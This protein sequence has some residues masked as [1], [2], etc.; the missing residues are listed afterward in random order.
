MDAVKILVLGAGAREHAIITALLREGVHEVVSAGGN[1]GNS[2]EPHVHAQLMDRASLWTGQGLPMGFADVRIGED[3]TPTTGLPQ[4]SE[5][6]I[7]D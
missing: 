7:A 1:S 3:A 6:L 2:S 5:H 4:N